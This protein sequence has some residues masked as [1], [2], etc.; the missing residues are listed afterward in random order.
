MTSAPSHVH[1]IGIGGAGVSALAR[2]FL[3][4]RDRV[5][6]CDIAETVAT[7]ALAAEGAAIVLGHD[8][9]HVLDAD[10][11]VHTSAVFGPALEEVAAARRAGARVQT[12][13]EVLADLIAGTDSVAVAGSHGK[14][15]ITHMLGHVLTA[16]GWDP[17]ILVGDRTHSR[18]GGSSW[19]VAEA[20]E[21]D[22]SLVLH[23]PAHAILTQVEFDHP[24]QFHDVAE[25]DALFRRFLA[26][27][28]GVALLCADD[29]RAAAMAAPGRR[30]TY[31]FHESADYRCEALGGG[32]YR[33]QRGGA[34]LAADRLSV[35]GR[36]NVQNATAAL[37]MAVELD[38][39]PAFAASALA[40]FEGAHRR[41]E[42]KGVWRGAALYDDYAHHPTEV[43]ATIA[44]ARELPHRRL[45]V[46]FQVHHFAR[47]AALRDDFAHSLAGA[48]VAVVA[49]IFGPGEENPWRASATQLVERAPNARFAPDLA[50]ARR[51]L[52]AEVRAGD[53]LLV[54]GA[55]E[56]WKLADD[57]ASEG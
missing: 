6:G 48:D 52:E 5:T 30:L 38:L 21:S 51:E 56:I 26:G 2:V 45:V 13:A 12:R 25:I 19:L 18:A 49:E 20:D 24:A 16:A 55:G 27:V 23:R 15:T 33:I 28:R 8:P 40:G 7:R 39:E 1:L 46:A 11:V 54:M 14:T 10:L 35:P 9:A 57:L 50:A 44:A 41:L 22:G 53:L 17:T 37:A 43:A 4:R 3:A 31:G 36:H 47:F 34:E 32:R 29:A 42:R